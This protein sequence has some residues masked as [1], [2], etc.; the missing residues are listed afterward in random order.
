MT[1]GTT[2]HL[3]RSRAGRR[4]DLRHARTRVD[5]AGTRGTDV[6]V[7]FV[8]THGRSNTEAQIGDLEVVPRRRVEYRGTTLR[9]DGRRRDPRPATPGRPRRRARAHERPRV[10]ER[11]AVA[12]RR[13][14]A[15][16]R[17]RRDLDGQHPAPRVDER[18]G[19]ARSRASS[20]AR[21]SPTRSCAGPSRSSSSTRRPRRSGAGWRTGTSTTAEKV[22]AALANYFRVGNLNALR[23]LALHVD[24]RPR[25][26]G[27]RDLPRGPR[28]HRDVGDAGARRGRDHR[29]P[30]R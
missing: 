1:R 6:V 26:R 12:G 19:R 4:Q 15:R 27:A 21:R 10:P 24:R 2:P 29:R 16:R 17:D 9:G 25:G 5:G 28:D 20:S 13:R 22:D 8:E 23:E 30:R 7:G 18:R 14:A 3:P 11:E